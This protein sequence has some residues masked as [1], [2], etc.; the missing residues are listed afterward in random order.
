MVGEDWCHFS[1]R[2]PRSRDHLQAKRASVPFEDER[3]AWLA[4]SKLRRSAFDGRARILAPPCETKPGME[5]K[6]CTPAGL[7]QRFVARRDK[8]AFAPLRKAT[9]G[10]VI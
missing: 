2:L 5:L 3:Y 1:Q 7:E 4:V 6:L 9:W 8:A 10:D